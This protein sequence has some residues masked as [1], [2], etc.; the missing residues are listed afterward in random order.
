MMICVNFRNVIKFKM[1]KE[2]LHFSFFTQ[3]E[4]ILQIKTFYSLLVL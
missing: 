2:N 4:R 3:I 1:Q